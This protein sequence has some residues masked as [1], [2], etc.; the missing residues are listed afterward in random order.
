MQNKD[1]TDEY[2]RQSKTKP[3]RHATKLSIKVLMKTRDN[4][5]KSAIKTNDKKH[6]NAYTFFRQEVKREIRLVERTYVKSQII[7]S[8]GNKLHMGGN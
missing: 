7:N 3:A 8:K 2:A 6:W 1:I 4:W 5:Y